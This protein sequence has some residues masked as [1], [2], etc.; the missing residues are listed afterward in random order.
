MKVS[1]FKPKTVTDYTA[2]ILILVVLYFVVKRVFS[3]SSKN[4]IP[5]VS[6][7]ISG[8]TPPSNS[9]AGCTDNSILRRGSRCPAV[10]KIQSYYNQHV[11]SKSAG[12]QNLVVD[13]IFGPK[14]E[15]VVN[16]VTGS[17]ETSFNNFK[18]RVDAQFKFFWE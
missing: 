15:A 1:I 16:L 13:D 3:K 6:N 9:G 11:A 14:T 7:I 8:N 17:K 5:S 12:I 2:I 18:S 4:I 10:G